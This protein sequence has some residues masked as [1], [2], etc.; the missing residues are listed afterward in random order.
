MAYKEPFLHQPFHELGFSR[1]F[2]V[3]NEQLGFFTL[4]DLLQHTPEYLRNLPAFS[5]DMLLEYVN[6]MENKG[7]GDYLDGL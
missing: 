2:C 7:V 5:R 4:N 6:F 3:V 1:E